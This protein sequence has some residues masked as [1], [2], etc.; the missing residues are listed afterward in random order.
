MGSEARIRGSKINTEGAGVMKVGIIIHTVTGHTANVAEE[1]SQ[2]L[3]DRGHVVDLMKVVPVHEQ[4]KDPKMM[5]LKEIPSVE[6]YELLIFGAPVHGFA[7]SAA[8][9][10]Y[11][12][13][14]S[15][16]DEKMAAIFVT[17][18]FPFPFMGG[19]RSVNQMKRICESKGADV[20]ETG[21]INWSRKTRQAKIEN[22]I[23]RFIDF[24][25]RP[26]NGPLSK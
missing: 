8:M 10:L 16:L 21:I 23:E 2:K 11:L 20:Y 18:S 9:R 5:Q 26:L 6:S 13:Q 14:L 25:D 19:N 15:D 4:V 24:S 22:M 12:E 1:L 7:V 17:Q 3:M